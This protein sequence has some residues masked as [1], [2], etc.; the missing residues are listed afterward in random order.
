VAIVQWIS[1]NVDLE[2]SMR[3]TAC[4][5]EQPAANDTPASN[6]TGAVVVLPPI[7]AENYTAPTDCQVSED[8]M[9]ITC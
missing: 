5:F 8:G 3:C 9:T 6:G 2:V 1:G 7:A 4:Q